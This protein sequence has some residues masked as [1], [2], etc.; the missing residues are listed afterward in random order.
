MSGYL[1]KFGKLTLYHIQTPFNTFAN[2]ADPDQAA[3]VRAAWSYRSTLFACDNASR[4][5]HTLVDL[6]SCFFVFVICTNVKV[7]III[8]SGLSLA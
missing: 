5:D 3:L 8:H 2:R 7:Y 1:F 4:Y 6:T